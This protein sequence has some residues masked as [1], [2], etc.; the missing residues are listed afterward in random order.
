[1]ISERAKF[2][3]SARAVNAAAS[4]AKRAAQVA[5]NRDAMPY[6]TELV[7]RLRETFGHGV[8][9]RYAQESGITVG[10]KLPAGI[11]AHPSVLFLMRRK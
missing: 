2:I 4:A 9:V 8:M 5:A 3:L 7:D 1:V 10:K 6:T 11:V